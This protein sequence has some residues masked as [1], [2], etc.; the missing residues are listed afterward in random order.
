MDKSKIIDLLRSDRR[1]FRSFR[2]QDPKGRLDLSG[3]E[4]SGTDLAGAP[5]AGVDLSNARLKGA[6]CTRANFRFA[7][8]SGADLRGAK[9]VGAN[10]HRT[11]LERANLEGAELGEEVDRETR[12]CLNVSSFRGAR[13]DREELETMLGILN[14][15]ER[16][17]IRYRIIPKGNSGTSDNKGCEGPV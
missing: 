1:K 4:L 14:E 8:L 9:L 12:M 11:V 17:E 6:D 10:L 13:L 2:D 3:A 16:W 5:L 7:D 15:N